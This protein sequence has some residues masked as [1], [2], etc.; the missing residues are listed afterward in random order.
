M[1]SLYFC[2]YQDTLIGPASSATWSPLCV[3]TQ[4]VVVLEVLDDSSALVTVPECGKYTF[5]YDQLEVD[6]TLQI[7]SLFTVDSISMDSVFVGLDSLIL[8][9]TICFVHDTVC[10]WFG[11]PSSIAVVMTTELSLEYDDLDCGQDL[12]QTACSNTIDIPPLDIDVEWCVE[13]NSTFVYQLIDATVV[14]D[15]LSDDCLAEEIQIDTIIGSGEGSFSGCFNQG[16]F[17]DPTASNWLLEIIGVLGGALGDL[18]GSFPPSEEFCEDGFPGEPGEPIDPDSCVIDVMVDTV[19]FV[20]VPILTGGQWTYVPAPD[21][22]ITLQD[23]TLITYND[24]TIAVIIDSSAMTYGSTFAVWH[25]DW[26]G[27]YNLPPFD[28]SIDVQWEPTWVLDSIPIVDVTVNYEGDCPPTSGVGCGGI[29]AQFF[30]GEIP[31]IPEFPCGPI[32]LDFFVDGLLVNASVIDC[33]DDGYQVQVNVDGGIPPYEIVGL[34][35]TWISTNVYLSDSLSY[36]APTEA[37]VF[38]SSSCSEEFSWNPCDCVGP[39]VEAGPNQEVTCL[40][41]CAVITGSFQAG[42]SPGSFEGTWFLANGSTDEFNGI[43]VCDLGTY[44]YFVEHIPSGCASQDAL[45]IS[46]PPV[47]PAING[48][49]QLNCNIQALDLQ[50]LDL[51]GNPGTTSFFWT[52]PSVSPQN[53]ENQEI[54]V[55]EGGVYQVEITNLVTGCSSISSTFIQVDTIPPV[56]ELGSDIELSCVDSLPIQISNNLGNPG[57][58]IN[59][60][61]SLDGN[62]TGNSLP[63]QTVD[64]VGLY[65][66]TITDLLNGCTANDEILITFGPPAELQATIDSACF[67]A[68]T[69]TVLLSLSNP[70]NTTIFYTLEGLPTQTNGDFTAVPA[71]LYTATATDSSACN[72]TLEILVPEIPEVTL[73]GGVDVI[74]CGQDQAFAEF[75]GIPLQEDWVITWPDGS[76]GSQIELVEAGAFTA[77]LETTCQRIELPY[78][79]E[80]ALIDLP[81]FEVPNIFTPNGDGVNDDW[82]PLTAGTFDTYELV[83]YNRFGQEV[84]TTTNPNIRWNGL[85]NGVAAPADVYAWTLKAL[86]DGCEEDFTINQ[87]GE[88]TLLR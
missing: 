59:Y 4:Q 68:P 42:F 23:T 76:T 51:N 71:G 10:Y 41:S 75:N 45:E 27:N 80:Q 63:I 58:V 6:S 46:I 19:D 73:T 47:I 5:V 87:Y 15:S 21:S 8:L 36:N 28:I 26:M 16:D 83:V 32:Q 24:S 61:W 88:V 40:D 25:F 34:P 53:Q 74:A 31:E 17:N 84:F 37:E 20:E 30:L 48:Q 78:A 38:D 3:D 14:S 57:L 86:Q 67:N 82:S 35:G 56:L 54:V 13:V 62:D 50:A 2:G 33:W 43:T 66:L 69:G 55:T 1:D 85:Q 65:G 18:S 64:E 44:V 49:S 29:S 81:N 9:D 52:G 12:L 70:P 79:L 72:F 39:F 11:D 22:V 7:D 60:D 77:I